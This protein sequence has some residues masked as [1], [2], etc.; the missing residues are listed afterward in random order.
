MVPRRTH[1]LEKA[2]DDPTLARKLH[3]DVNPGDKAAEDR[4]KKVAAAYEVLNDEARRKAMAYGG[5]FFIG[6]AGMLTTFSVSAWIAVPVAAA[7]AYA[8]GR[9]IF[10]NEYVP[11]DEEM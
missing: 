4:F 3:P 2:E 9:A 8:G 11:E 6:I 5:L 7:V 1:A 10:N